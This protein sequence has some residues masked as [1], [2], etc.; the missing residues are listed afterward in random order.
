MAF[1]IRQVAYKNWFDVPA[2]E[3]EAET[4][5]PFLGVTGAGKS[6]NVERVK[7]Q[8]KAE[9]YKNLVDNENDPSA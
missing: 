1:E 2:S 5:S 4:Q 9:C 3:L 6:G 8:L 7:Q